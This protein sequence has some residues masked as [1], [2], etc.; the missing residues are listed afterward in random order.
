MK[1]KQL[2]TSVKAI[3]IRQGR[4][5]LAKYVDKVGDWYCLPGGGQLHGEPLPEALRRECLE[6]IGLQVRV[7]R[8]VFVRDY[9][10]K[11]H[12]FA[13]TDSYLHQVEL[14]FECEVEGEYE[15]AIG[16]TPDVGQEGAAWLELMK[17]K[18][19]RVYPKVLPD[20]LSEGVPSGVVYLG[21]VN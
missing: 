12:E 10:A 19:Y 7:G 15:P 1:P 16:A 14:M 13:E 2:R 21:D 20:L 6:E 5:L 9:I 8:L 11:N 18:D 17:L 3:I 4:I